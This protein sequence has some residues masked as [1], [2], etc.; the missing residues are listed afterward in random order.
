MS[1]PKIY[2]SIN[3]D[4]FSIINGNRNISIKKVDRIIDDINRGLNLLAY[5]PIIVYLKGD[6]LMIVDGQHRFTVSK[7]LNL[8][9]FYVIAEALELKNIARLNSRQDKW[10]QLD[11]LKCYIKIG[12]E[13]YE[14][15]QS[16]LDEFEVGISTT[17]QFLMEGS[18]IGARRD[19]GQKF[20]DGEFKVNYLEEVKELF[21][22]SHSLFDRY[23]FYKD[24]FLISAVQAIAKKGLCDFD[25][26]KEKIDAAPMEMDKQTSMKNYIYNIERVYNYKNSIR[27]VIF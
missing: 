25:L 15:L 22:L 9:V 19:S 23:R 20:S 21:T 10:S 13:D 3:Y 4:E 7:K 27:K 8:P 2:S 12:I 24:R 5:S 6:E 11:F 14:I 17:A 26:L 1:I 16:V 18:I